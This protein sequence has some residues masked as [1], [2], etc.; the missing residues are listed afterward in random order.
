[1]KETTTVEQFKKIFE[2]YQPIGHSAAERL[3]N[4]DVSHRGEMEKP[5]LMQALRELGVKHE[6]L[7]F[8]AP[9]A[10][11]VGGWIGHRP[12]SNFMKYVTDLVCNRERKIEGMQEYVL[13][14]WE[15]WNFVQFDI[16]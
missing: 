13:E 4:S 16:Q 1:M 12:D 9:S 11:V 10:T 2:V 8:V 7:L 5:N 3:I 14:L 6:L 15:E